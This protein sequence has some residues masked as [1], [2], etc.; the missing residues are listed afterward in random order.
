MPDDGTKVTGWLSSLRAFVAR[1]LAAE[2][3]APAQW[4]P[5]RGLGLLN[6]LLADVRA[7]SS[8]TVLPAIQRDD[9]GYSVSTAREWCARAGL[10]ESVG[11]LAVLLASEA[12]KIDKWPQ[13]AWAIGESAIN[14]A[15]TV[16][17]DETLDDALVRRVVGDHRPALA[18]RFGPQ[19]GR[20]ASTRQQPTR[21]H[22]RC[23]ELLWAR[24]EADS[25]M[26][27]AGRWDILAHGATQW[28]D[29]ETQCVMHAKKPAT[30]PTPEEVMRRRYASGRHWVG[31]L[32]DAMG[33][34][35][36]DPWVLS[37]IGPEG[38]DEATAQAMLK[39][40]RKRWRR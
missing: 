9:A 11:V 1:S 36:I 35:V 33:N 4:T 27:V 32:V 23:A 17:R 18:G 12:P 2:P 6:G 8:A 25:E 19:G 31:P 21:R 39:D 20:W 38:V 34:V 37:L 14:A 28:T 26:N 29:N 3:E 24:A 30:N 13:Y 5:P 15:P 10:P 22:V 40:G 7:A 16:A